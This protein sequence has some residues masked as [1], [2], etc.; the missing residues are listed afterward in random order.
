[1]AGSLPQNREKSYLR[2]QIRSLRD[3]LDP[4]ERILKSQVIFE[5]MASSQWFGRAQTVLFYAS[6][7]SEVETWEMMDASRKMGKRIGLPRV[8]E[9]SGDLHIFE[10]RDAATELLP[11]Y[12]GIWEPVEDEDRRLRLD[13]I[14][15]VL[16][17]GLAFDLKGYRLGYG[18]GYYDRLLARWGGSRLSVGLAFDVQ[19]VEELPVS[20]QDFRLSLV[21][22]ETRTIRGT[23]QGLSEAPADRFGGDYF[24]AGR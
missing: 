17:P 24:S 4:T 12:K 22:T 11:G 9:G 16:V 1:M 15:L 18:G 21:L 20:G 3:S 14:D 19:V 5:R 6:F 10:V 13:Q 8:E 2:R 7:G 23:G